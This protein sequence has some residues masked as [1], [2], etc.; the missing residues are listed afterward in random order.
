MA[1]RSL[2][3][4]S[5]RL[6]LFARNTSTLACSS[7]S[8]DN[9]AI[10]RPRLIGAIPKQKTDSAVYLPGCQHTEALR[11]RVSL[12]HISYPPYRYPNAFHFRNASF[13]DIDIVCGA[14]IGDVYLCNSQL[15][16]WARGSN[17]QSILQA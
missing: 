17:V 15:L 16:D 7:E 4:Q 3:V 12:T 8:L 9:R 13:D 2:L 1:S 6:F 5:D 14:C 10:R 11:Q